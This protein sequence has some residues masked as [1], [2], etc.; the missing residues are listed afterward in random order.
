MKYTRKQTTPPYA[1]IFYLFPLYFLFSGLKLFQF[2]LHLFS[3][4]EALIS[5][6]SIFLFCLYDLLLFI[7]FCR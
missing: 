6:I 7:L 3:V 4:P 2:F 5:P 1:C